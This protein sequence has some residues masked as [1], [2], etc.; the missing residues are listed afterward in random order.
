MQECTSNKLAE[1]NQAEDEQQPKQQ[2]EQRMYRSVVYTSVRQFSSADSS[3][4]E[5]GPTQTIR[6]DISSPTLTDSSS[7]E[8]AIAAEDFGYFNAA[9]EDFDE[10]EEQKEKES[11]SETAAPLSRPLEVLRE[12][13]GY[14]DNV[15]YSDGS[16]ASEDSLSGSES[17]KHFAKA[18]TVV[19]EITIEE[20][21]TPDDGQWSPEQPLTVKLALPAGA[22][23]RQPAPLPVASLHVVEVKESPVYHR[24]IQV[25]TLNVEFP[26]PE[27][28]SMEVLSRAQSPD[29]S[30][31]HPQQQQSEQQPSSGN[32]T[33]HFFDMEQVL[34][35]RFN[36]KTTPPSAT[37]SYVTTPP[38][39]HAPPPT[40]A[41]DSAALFNP[42][43]EPP[44]IVINECRAH[45][46]A[47]NEEEEVY[48][49]AWDQVYDEISFQVSEE[50]SSAE[51]RRPESRLTGVAAD[52]NFYT[53]EVPAD[54]ALSGNS[55]QI[56]QGEDEILVKIVEE[57]S[58]LG[59]PAG[60]YTQN[61]T[62]HLPQER[63]YKEISF[64]ED[65]DDLDEE[66]QFD[67]LPFDIQEQLEIVV[68]TNNSGMSAD[69]YQETILEEDD[70]VWNHGVVQDVGVRR[71]P[72][73][74]KASRD[75]GTQTDWMSD[76]PRIEAPDVSALPPTS[77]NLQ[78]QVGHWHPDVINVVPLADLFIWLKFVRMNAT[79]TVASISNGGRC[80]SVK[81]RY[82]RLNT[83]KST[84]LN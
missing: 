57:T 31:S 1:E 26:S 16:D 12:D 82:F 32:N 35:E 24:M 11:R 14:V 28:P 69:G 62:V 63:Q 22:D 38:E 15:N 77:V 49:D 51:A 36:L 4:G 42:S 55:M 33:D 41:H 73:T 53:A 13:I 23:A 43:V 59:H 83:I 64:N 76:D 70:E 30:S 54:A 65:I 50:I 45:E 72:L 10:P 6:M 60:S 19:P 61:R 5:S 8:T 18:A 71:A 68:T 29:E 66:A 67:S 47:L 75:E 79:A 21:L 20:P 37:L 27:Q 80:Y 48:E 78:L 84:Q 52:A 74:R 46:E 40:P 39:T 2:P 25:E 56:E 81:C 17:V 44:L 3:A 34:V 9:F 58:L 7:Q